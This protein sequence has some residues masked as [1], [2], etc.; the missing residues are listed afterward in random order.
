MALHAGGQLIQLVA[1]GRGLWTTCAEAS[2][3]AASAFCGLSWAKVLLAYENRG[4]RLQE[5]LLGERAEARTRALGPSV[6]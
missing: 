5:A 3:F 1:D 2:D 4:R 6:M